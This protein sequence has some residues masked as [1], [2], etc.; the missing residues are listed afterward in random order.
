MYAWWIQG[1]AIHKMDKRKGQI[2]LSIQNFSEEP[3]FIYRPVYFYPMLVL[4]VIKW[5]EQSM[6]TPLE[7]DYKSNSG[8]LSCSQMNR[9][10]FHNFKH[11]K[12]VSIYT[13]SSSSHSQAFRVIS[14]HYCTENSFT[15]KVSSSRILV[16]KTVIP[17]V[18]ILALSLLPK[19]LVSFFLQSTT[20]VTVFFSTL[21]PTRC[22]LWGTRRVGDY[23]HSKWLK[24]ATRETCLT[25]KP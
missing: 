15:S 13:W 3:F 14:V 16:P 8:F 10:C 25:L 2:L 22:H 17:L 1:F 20:M 19:G 12:Y 6:Q 9:C 21:M 11:L 4:F 5:A 23:K 18:S 24:A 7:L